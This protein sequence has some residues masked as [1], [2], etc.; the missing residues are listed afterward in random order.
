MRI[1]V[2]THFIQIIQSFIYGQGLIPT[3]DL[4]EAASRFFDN[5]QGRCASGSK[6]IAVSEVKIGPS[7]DGFVLD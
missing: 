6:K 2:K 5:A 7:A 3:K 4:N 1:K